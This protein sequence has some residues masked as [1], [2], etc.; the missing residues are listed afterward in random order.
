MSGL[1]TNCSHRS[2]R[3]SSFTATPLELRKKISLFPSDGGSSFHRLRSQLVRSEVTSN[4]RS[5]ILRM[6]KSSSFSLHAADNMI[7]SA[8]NTSRRMN[9]S[10]ELFMC[11][12]GFLNFLGPPYLLR[13]VADEQCH[14]TEQD[15][16]PGQPQQAVS[17]AVVQRV[18]LGG[19]H[20]LNRPAGTAQT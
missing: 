20:G 4:V 14:R 2:R 3:A 5:P 12:D 13:G 11:V 17:K 7:T 10:E 16:H 6:A 18:Q 15:D 8:S 19:V 9:F 1:A